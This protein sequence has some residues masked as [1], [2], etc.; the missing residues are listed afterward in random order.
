MRP[1]RL[2]PEAL[3]TLA[4]VSAGCNKPASGKGQQVPGQPVET[5]AANAPDQ[6][7][8]FEGQTRAP[9]RT[10]GVAFDVRVV[11][12]ELEHPWSLAF[13]PGGR[14][15]VTERPGRLRVIAPDGARSEPLAGV[16]RVANADQG[17]LL[18]VA[19]APTFAQDGTV[20][21]TYSE[22]REGGNGTALARGRLSLDGTPRLE[23]VETIWRMTPTLDSSKHFGS[24]IVF[25]P[26]GDLFVT[27]GERSDLE[28]RRQA[29]RLDS[30]FGKIVRLRPDGAPAA[31]NPFVGREGALPEIWSI[32]HRNVQAAAL[33]PTTKE[34][35][36]VD[37]GPR[38]GDEINVARRGR[39][40]GWP[41]ISY[42]IE[43]RGDKIGDGLTQKE[44]MEQ[45]LYYWDPVIAPSG[46]AFYDADLFP[47][48]KG[49]LFVGSLAG[50][51]LVRLTLDGERVVGEERLLVDRGRV[52]DVRVGPT[53]SVYVL[54]DES[55]GELLELVPKR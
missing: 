54:T 26:D 6:R 31:D 29:Q 3:V 41:T 37:H 30:A 47:A 19:L 32:G 36:I 43:Y 10:E 20:Y 8:A 48:W 5:R 40:Y 35:W 1:P 4:V 11:A 7:P 27:L 52:R 55:N 53:G 23:G 44:G 9:Y 15:L 21:L 12:R 34:L 17:G 13:L 28:G 33:H 51:H 16:P 18:D 2:L 38:G 50:K 49:S 46:A 25:A 42:G 45:P 39:D 14:L 24:R 22:P